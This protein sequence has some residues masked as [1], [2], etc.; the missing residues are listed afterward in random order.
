MSVPVRGK[1]PSKWDDQTARHITE[2]FQALERAL[3]GG[4]PV[5]LS[6][7]IPT[8]GSG[9]VVPGGPG[10]GGGGVTDHGA[11]TGLA[12]DDHPQYALRGEQDTLQPHVHGEHDV[13]GLENRLVVRGESVRPSAHTHGTQDVVGSDEFVRRGE[14]VRTTAHRHVLAD[15][16][17][18]NLWEMMLW[19]RVF[20]G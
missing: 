1:V 3:A 19:Q 13:R 9:T 6:P 12:D 10:G 8:F 17:D 5:F 7:A 2:R 14:S 16:A 11:L 15:V 20:G 4:A 18:H